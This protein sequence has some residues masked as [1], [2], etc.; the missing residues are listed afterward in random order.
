MHIRM[1]IHPLNSTTALARTE[2]CPIHY[3]CSNVL[4]IRICAYICRIITSQF[5]V[6]RHDT[7]RGSLSEPE[8]ASC[9]TGESNELDFRDLGNLIQDILA[10]NVDY[11][12]DVW[13]ETGL[14]EEREQSFGDYRCLGRCS[15]N[16]GVSG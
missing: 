10:A 14:V 6:Q 3:L 2:Y 15:E 4:Q 1:N 5:Q 9:G 13:R 7:P 12:Q 16:N 8:S 11:L